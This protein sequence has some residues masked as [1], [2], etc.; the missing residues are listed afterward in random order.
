MAV[1]VVQELAFKRYV[2]PD[3]ERMGGGGDN[4]RT[5]GDSVCDLQ[6]QPEKLNKECEV[7]SGINDPS[8]QVKS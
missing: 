4:G 2:H 1:D 6:V 7:P 5:G 8:G 3:R